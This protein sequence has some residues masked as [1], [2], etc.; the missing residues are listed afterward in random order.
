M[1]AFDLII[2]GATGF[3][4]GL[5]VDYIKK[6]YPDVNFAIAG[7]NENK[8]RA[9]SEKYNKPIDY[10]TVESTDKNGLA[11]LAASASVILNTA[12]PFYKYGSLVV[13][14]CVKE[15]THYIDITGES[16]WVREQIEKHHEEAAKRGVRIINACGFDSI[17]SDIGVFFAVNSV[18][19]KIKKVSGFHSWKGEASG[20][21]IETMFTSVEAKSAKGGFGRFSLNPQNTVSK[22]QAD[23]TSDKVSVKKIKHLNG[24]TGPFVMALPNTRTVRRSAALSKETGKYYGKDFVYT[25]GA[26]YSKLS[27]ALK[28]TLMTLFLGLI[29]FSP[30]RSFFRPLFRKPGQ[31]PSKAVMD[32]G[33]FKTRFLVE[34]DERVRAF[35]V[36]ASGDPG[37]KMTSRMACESALCL[38]LEN[39]DSLPGGKNFGGVITPS[40]GLGDVLVQRLKKIGVTFNEIML[41]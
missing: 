11:L 34:T 14:S 6:N 41:D 16:F 36:S 29:I 26:Y 5:C 32:S 1:K 13:E 4:G 18:K 9:I 15:N 20:G 3:T 12:G 19:E 24:Y 31:G 2:Y 17:P 28:V 22:H 27:S 33:F 21:T 23:N 7:R 25:E 38:I 37:Y 35:M 39:P 40:I 10:F 30:F 8:L